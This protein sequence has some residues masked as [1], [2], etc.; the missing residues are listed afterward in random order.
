MLRH[1]LF[2]VSGFAWL[3][4]GLYIQNWVPAVFGSFFLSI[5]FAGLDT[6]LLEDRVETLR[7][8]VRRLM[9]KMAELKVDY[10]ISDVMRWGSEVEEDE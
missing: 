8:D 7:K 6:Q 2:I 10:I 5:G 4:Y 3:V 9:C 1:F